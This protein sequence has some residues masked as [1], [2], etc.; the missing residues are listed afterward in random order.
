V[1]ST[2]DNLVPQ[3]DSKS[4]PLWKNW[5]S[6]AGAI[7][8]SGS[9]FAFLLLFSMDMMGKGK[10][11]PYLGILCYVITPG[12]LAFGLAIVFWGMWRQ[13]KR[14]NTAKDLN[15]S[16]VLEIDFSRP[17]DRRILI[18][19]IAAAFIYLVLTAIGSYQTYIYTES[20]NFCGMVCHQ[21]MGPEITSYK[22][23]SHAHVACVECH[24][25]EGAASYITAKINGVHQL[26]GIT[27]NT[28]PRPIPT[29][30]HNMR[31]AKETCEHCHWSEKLTGDLQR[32][33]NHFMADEKNTPYTVRLVIKAGSGGTIHNAPGGIHWHNNPDTKI[34]Y[35]A[36]DPQRQVIPWVRLTERDGTVTV[37]RKDGF[38]DEPKANQILKMD[39]LSCH[40]R[41]AHKY[42]SPNS[43]MDEALYL[44]RVD[45]TLPSIKRVAV[46]LLTKPYKT[47]EEAD[48][49]ITAE[50]KKKYPDTKNL[51]GTISGVLRVYH[52]NFFPEMKVDWSKYPENIGHMDTLGCFRCHDDKHIAEGGKHLPATTCTSCHIILAQGAG[53][54]LEHLTRK[55]APFKHPSSDINGVD[56]T[57]SDCHNGK[58][59]DN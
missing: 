33:F 45:K 34:E 5:T 11:N 18:G 12:F 3:P 25:G 37:F 39:C 8:A 29:P 42:S 41:P 7:L 57:C 56:L 47:S 14:I 15:R 21:A 19:F 58:N 16:P 2:P 40:N 20:D 35:F 10:T 46:D 26:I 51:D 9:L 55:G 22:N 31:P 4:Q 36:S 44:G 23:Y 50:L 54:E 17:K 53:D 49:V 27:F 30:V 48:T 59:Q 13:R 28:Y 24:V 1:N 32:T 52:N 38:K 43:A 6:I